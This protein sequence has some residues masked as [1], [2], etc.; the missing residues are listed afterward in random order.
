MKDTNYIDKIVSDSIG[1]MNVPVE[2]NWA[3]MSDTL[4]NLPQAEI[5]VNNGFLSTITSKIVASV[6]FVAAIISAIF[7]INPSK[8]SSNQ[9]T[10]Q[11]PVDI[12]IEIITTREVF[13]TVE[14]GFDDAVE[15]I[16]DNNQND[17]QIVV[18]QVADNQDDVVE[19]KDTTVTQ[20]TIITIEQTQID[21]I[22]P[23]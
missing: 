1:E 8:Q 7:I 21:T 15:I 4:Q 17:N 12:K 5:P 18:E 13:V 2:T 14:S 6:A 22:R 9:E 20:V 16:A 10:I 19:Q 23:E 11:K 3:E